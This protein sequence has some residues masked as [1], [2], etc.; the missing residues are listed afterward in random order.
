MERNKICAKREITQRQGIWNRRDEQ[1]MWQD[2]ETDQA[3]NAEAEI[4]R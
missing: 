3:R 4:T 1:S 2:A